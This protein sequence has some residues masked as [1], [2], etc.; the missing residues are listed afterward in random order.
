M[1]LAGGGQPNDRTLA[2]FRRENAAA[3]TAVFPETVILALRVGLARLGHVA[4][5]GPKLQANPSTHEAMSYGRMRRREAQ[6]KEEIARLI[7]PVEAQETA[8]DQDDG[9]DADGSSVGEELARR[10]ARLTKIQAARE[11]LEAEQRAAQGLTE[12][13][14][15]GIADTEQRSFA[16]TDARSMLLQHGAFDDAYNA[17]AGVDGERG[18]LVVAE[19]TTIAAD[20][21]H[22]P[23][24]ASAVRAL[25][26]IAGL[27]DE[28]PT[29]MS[30]DAGSCSGANAAEDGAG[31]DLVIAAGRNDPAGS[32][33]PADPA[34]PPTSATPAAAA[35]T[36]VDPS[37]R[38]VYDPGRD[39]WVCPADTLLLRPEPVPGAPGRPSHHR[40]V[41]ATVDCAACPLRARCRKP[42][43]Q[44]RELNA[45]RSRLT[46][47]L[48]FKRRQPEARRRYA[49]R[50]AIVEPVFGQLKDARGFTSCTLR[51]LALVTGEY[52]LA[53]LAH[54]LG[55]LLRVCVLPSSR[56]A[57]LAA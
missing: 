34:D 39:V 12:D 54:T 29:T 26:E 18:V 16:D 40:Y 8:E 55:K 17:Q 47:A 44:R 15:P 32:T 57:P 41:A 31:L 4:F 49:R 38:C 36:T 56:V 10:E 23:A 14:S 6:L 1:S 5:D 51:G 46:G 53:C 27:P 28:L 24:A 37:T 19:L 30:A 20:G 50:K 25:R 2:R 13:A 43:E 7:E 3:F 21:G 42:G 52:L 22:R 33:D 11:H 9:R 45:Q 48:R 35:Q